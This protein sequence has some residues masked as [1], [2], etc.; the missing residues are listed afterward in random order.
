MRYQ[1][2]LNAFVEK[3]HD[4]WWMPG[5]TILLGLGYFGLVIGCIA[6]VVLI[7]I[8]LESMGNAGIWVSIIVGALTVFYYIGKIARV[9]GDS[10]WERKQKN[11]YP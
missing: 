1:A 2:W 3:H 4:D 9:P 8:V 10:E 6:L 5:F 7:A 11:E